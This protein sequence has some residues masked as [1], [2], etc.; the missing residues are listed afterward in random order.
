[1]EIF[2]VFRCSRKIKKTEGQKL[3]WRESE[4]DVNNKKGSNVGLGLESFR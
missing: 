4:I 2:F 3:E 1:M